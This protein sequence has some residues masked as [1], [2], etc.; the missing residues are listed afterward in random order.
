MGSSQLRMN[1]GNDLPRVQNSML[2]LKPWHCQAPAPPRELRPD[3]LFR[4]DASTVRLVQFC[5]ALSG[6]RTASERVGRWRPR[7]GRL[8]YSRGQL[9][10]T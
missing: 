7:V 6:P 3:K 2:E 4:I 5:H 1:C 9:D 8:G 10:S